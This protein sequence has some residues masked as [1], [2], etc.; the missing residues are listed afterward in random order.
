M[1]KYDL[2]TISRAFAWDETPK[3]W[4][5]WK[6]LSIILVAELAIQES[7]YNS[8]FTKETLA[9]VECGV[10]MGCCTLTGIKLFDFLFVLVKSR[11][12]NKIL[13]LDFCDRGSSYFVLLEGCV[14]PTSL[15]GVL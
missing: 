9:N 2:D 8:G 13:D 7:F 10:F 15:E 11:S 12:N 1:R 3:P 4:N 5:I 6:L 14:L